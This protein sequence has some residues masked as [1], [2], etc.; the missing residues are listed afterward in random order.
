MGLRYNISQKQ[1]IDINGDK[2]KKLIAGSIIKIPVKAIHKVKSGESYSTISDKYN[3]KIKYICFASG[4]K[5]G[6]Q[7]REGQILVIPLE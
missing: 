2:A 6:S 3:V 4:I 5:S 1:L 7:L